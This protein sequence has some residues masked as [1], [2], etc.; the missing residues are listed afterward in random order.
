MAYNSVHEELFKGE[1]ADAKFG[2]PELQRLFE[3]QTVVAE[4]ARVLARYLTQS[5]NEGQVQLEEKTKPQTLM[6]LMHVLKEYSVIS[7]SAEAKLRR[8]VREV[9]SPYTVSMQEALELEDMDEKGEISFAAFRGAL[10]IEQVDEELLE[11]MTFFV[12]RQSQHSERMRY[13]C[14]MTLLEGEE[15][16]GEEEFEKDSHSSTVR[17]K[18]ITNEENLVKSDLL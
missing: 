14:L 6:A 17:V 11:F 13:Q 18:S 4:D 16:Y 1:P 3:R 5:G 12:F 9:L 2:A 7:K 15:E 8:R 10:R